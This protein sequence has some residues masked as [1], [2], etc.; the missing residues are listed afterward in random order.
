[1]GVCVCVKIYRKCVKCMYVCI[2]RA[3]HD[4]WTLLQEVISYI[5]VIKKSS[6]KHVSDFGRLRS[7]DRLNLKIEGNYYCQ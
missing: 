3:F 2:Y 6:Y 7:Y 4:L 5:F 1:M